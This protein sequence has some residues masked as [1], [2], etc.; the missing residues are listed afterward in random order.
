MSTRDYGDNTEYANPRDQW[1]ILYPVLLRRKLDHPEVRYDDTLVY[2]ASSMESAIDWCKRNTDIERRDNKDRWWWFVITEE[3][4]D[5][6]YSGIKGTMA[7]L[8]W[9][10][11][12]ATYD[13]VHGYKQEKPIEATSISDRRLNN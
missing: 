1:T 10:A 4:I 7:V 12:P 2:L 9:D 13:P 3:A 6:D 5:G 8:T 11:E